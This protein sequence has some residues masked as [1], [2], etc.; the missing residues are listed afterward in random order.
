MA[1][2]SGGGDAM[3]SYDILRLNRLECYSLCNTYKN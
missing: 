1:S 3:R 2:R